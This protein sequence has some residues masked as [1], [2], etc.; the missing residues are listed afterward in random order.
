M[1]DYACVVCLRNSDGRDLCGRCLKSYEATLG[2][3]VMAVI[4]WAAD[5]AR[6]FAR[7]QRKGGL[8]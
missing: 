1:T 5:R 4:V 2:G 6:Y 3:D 7:R 8:P